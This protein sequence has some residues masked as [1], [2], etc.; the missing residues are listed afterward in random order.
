LP[1]DAVGEARMAT[2]PLMVQ[3]LKVIAG[4]GT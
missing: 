4:E 2:G 1:K 3:A